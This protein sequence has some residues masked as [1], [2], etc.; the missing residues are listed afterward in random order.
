MVEGSEGV[1]ASLDWWHTAMDCGS[2]GAVS[3][4]I[5]GIGFPGQKEAR[6][7]GRAG[8]RLKGR[9]ITIIG[10]GQLNLWLDFI[11]ANEACSEP[12]LEPH[13]GFW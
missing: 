10:N 13:G 2:V 1:F 5:V 8:G 7:Q 4:D 9:R 12:S 11:G 6:A 3:L